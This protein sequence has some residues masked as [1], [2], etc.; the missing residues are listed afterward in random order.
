[1][2]TEK[3]RQYEDVELFVRPVSDYPHSDDELVFEATYKEMA[4]L[5]TRTVIELLGDYE[6]DA[7]EWRV[8]I[9]ERGD[10]Q[11]FVNFRVGDVEARH[12]PAAELQ[13]HAAAVLNHWRG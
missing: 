12:E 3:A 11:Y 10:E 9:R 4:R 8:G 5:S 2:A 1:M 13:N 7:G 6:L